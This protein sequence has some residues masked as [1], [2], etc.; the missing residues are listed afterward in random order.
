MT[1]DPPLHPKSPNNMEVEPS[2]DTNF[3][4]ME[5]ADPSD[6]FFAQAG[7]NF[8]AAGSRVSTAELAAVAAGE[9]MDE[10]NKDNE[11]DNNL[12]AHALVPVTH[13]NTNGTRRQANVSPAAIRRRTAAAT[14]ARRHHA[15]YRKSHPAPPLPASGTI[16]RPK[17]HHGRG[18]FHAGHWL[19]LT[20]GKWNAVLVS[21]PA[22][23]ES[24]SDDNLDARGQRGGPVFDTS[25]P[26]SSSSTRNWMLSSGSTVRSVVCRC[27][28][29]FTRAVF[30]IQIDGAH[31]D[32][33]LSRCA[34][35]WAAEAAVKQF[36]RNHKNGHGTD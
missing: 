21:L 4:P 26:V 14:E 18:D 33:P 19:H 29:S 8:G 31:Q 5:L 11:D 12:V 3:G 2:Q 23:L 17:G 27:L 16:A 13:A 6:P 24:R 7:T 32:L 30:I 36:L 10:D 9:K 34:S 1:Q 22:A 15:A 20:A 28:M 25:S 35:H